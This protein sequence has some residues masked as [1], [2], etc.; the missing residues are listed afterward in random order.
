[1]KIDENGVIRK[2]IKKKFLK[3]I[4]PLKINKSEEN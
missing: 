3:E 4:Q 1:M 2:M